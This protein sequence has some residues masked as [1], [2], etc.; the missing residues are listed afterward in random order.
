MV[1]YYCFPLG[2]FG[3]LDY[4]FPQRDGL[5]GVISSWPWVVIV[6]VFPFIPDII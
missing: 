1:D 6:S 5:L 4:G 2:G 3:C